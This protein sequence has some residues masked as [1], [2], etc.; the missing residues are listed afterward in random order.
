MCGEG[1]QGV[2]GGGERIPESEMGIEVWVVLGGNGISQADEG[3]VSEVVTAALQEAHPD[4]G[5]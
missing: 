5:P 4:T 1:G 2:L 3:V